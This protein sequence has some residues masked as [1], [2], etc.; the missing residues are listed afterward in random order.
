MLTV[1]KPR[2]ILAFSRTSSSTL[3]PEN[4]LRAK[5]STLSKITLCSA[6]LSNISATMDLSSSLLPAKIEINVRCKFKETCRDRDTVHRT[7]DKN[8][9]P[10]GEANG[11]QCGKV[12]QT[13]EAMQR[14]ET[15]C[16]VP[17]R[18][19][20]MRSMT[21]FLCFSSCKI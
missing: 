10:R 2:N 17:S 5:R 1:F 20:E 14:T 9:V 15:L 12:L 21:L 7:Y 16:P 6:S 11:M 4:L 18:E 3:R 19:R 8:P 13:G